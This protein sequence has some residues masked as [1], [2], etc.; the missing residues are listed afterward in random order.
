MKTNKKQI[1]ILFL[2]AVLL[3]TTVSF[4]SAYRNRQK[5]IEN[6]IVFGDLELKLIENT[7]D[8]SGKEVPYIETEEN[9][10]KQDSVSRIVKVENVCDNDMYVRIALNMIAEKGD[11]E[12]VDGNDYVSYDINENDWKYKDGYYYYRYVLKQRETTENLFENIYFDVDSISQDLS[13]GQL[14]LDVKV[15]AVQS[16]NNTDNALSAQ[17]WPQ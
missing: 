7:I 12:K 2:L 5:T 13:G 14:K 17:G 16:K 9:I 3:F 8:D 1:R 4:S 15:Q 6:H 10:S 11:K